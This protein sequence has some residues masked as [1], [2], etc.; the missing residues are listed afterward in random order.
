MKQGYFEKP[1]NVV[2]SRSVQ[3]RATAHNISPVLGASQR[4]AGFNPPGGSFVSSRA[5][6]RA[7]RRELGPLLSGGGILIDPGGVAGEPNCHGQRVSHGANPIA[8]FSTW[9][10]SGV[11]PRCRRS[12]GCHTEGRVGR[13]ELRRHGFT[14]GIMICKPEAAPSHRAGLCWKEDVIGGQFLNLGLLPR[15]HYLRKASV[16]FPTFLYATAQPT[17]D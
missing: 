3:R 8:A 16:V 11:Y 9:P 12:H 10:A 13:R 6:V 17:C 7:A 4:A 15:L 5:N 14:L 1:A 2:V